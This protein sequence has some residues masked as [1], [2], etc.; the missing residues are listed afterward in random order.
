M[1]SAGLTLV[2]GMIGVP[3]SAH[4]SF[5]IAETIKL[6]FCNHPVASTSPNTALGVA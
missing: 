3:D 6:L 1:V 2:F 4:A 5:Y